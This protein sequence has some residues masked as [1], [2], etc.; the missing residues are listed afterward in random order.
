MTLQVFRCRIALVKGSSEHVI[1]SNAIP[2]S[3]KLPSWQC[4][5]QGKI[6]THGRAVGR[7][8][9]SVRFNSRI[10]AVQSCWDPAQPRLWHGLAPLSARWRSVS[11][12]ADRQWEW[13]QHK[14]WW[15]MLIATSSIYL[16]SIPSYGWPFCMELVSLCLS[17]C[18]CKSVSWSMLLPT[19]QPSCVLRGGRVR[20][21]VVLSYMARVSYLLVWAVKWGQDQS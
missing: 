13:Y 18:R 5:R 16:G 9:R 15:L 4:S 8:S 20:S 10:K 21:Q 12:P 17:G 2:F 3:C 14:V 11:S 6:E 1:R 19:S 7:Y